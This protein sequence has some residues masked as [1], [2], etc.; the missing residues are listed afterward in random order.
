LFSNQTGLGIAQEQ[1]V[2]L[3]L[4]GALRRLMDKVS[5]GSTMER[6]PI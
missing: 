2:Q 3:F 4:R 6:K 5:L 1:V